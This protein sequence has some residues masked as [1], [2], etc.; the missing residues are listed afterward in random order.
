MIYKYSSVVISLSCIA[1]T[2][3]KY[4]WLG[5][6]M[7]FR[8]SRP[9]AQTFFILLGHAPALGN[10]RLTSDVFFFFFLG[11]FLR[12]TEWE[13]EQGEGKAFAGKKV[14]KWQICGSVSTTNQ[15]VPCRNK[16]SLETLWRE[17]MNPSKQFW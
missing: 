2:L 15:D 12:P 17:I 1:F 10:I 5:C 6:G 14:S 9:V 16:S 3:N 11:L 8:K 7:W 13:M 4:V